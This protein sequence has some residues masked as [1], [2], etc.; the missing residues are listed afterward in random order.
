MPIKDNRE[1]RILQTNLEINDDY[2]IEGYATTFNRYKLYEYDGVE[3]FEEFK[4]S[5]FDD[6]DMSDIIMQYD[7]E[8][9]VLAR[10]SNSTLNVTVDS[11]GLFVRADLSK[12]ESARNLYEEIKNGLVTKM[13]WAFPKS[14][15]GHYD[16]K[17]RTF[18]WEKIN[19]IYDVSAV[20]IPANQDTSIYARG[21]FD[22]VIEEE[23]K[24]FAK[25]QKRKQKLK[26]LC[27][28]ERSIK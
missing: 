28:I 6:A 27:E 22:G 19:K 12:S 10:I 20:S 17:T 15:K 21:F 23:R 16:T 9:K 24:E 1:Y 18:I 14:S 13:S 2:V 5:A 8:G 3:F 26:L 25:L 11:F 4:R 7:H